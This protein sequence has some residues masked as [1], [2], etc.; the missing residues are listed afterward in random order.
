MKKYFVKSLFRGWCEVDK[1][2]FDSFVEF[3]R[4]ETL[5][6]PRDKKDEYIATRTKIVEE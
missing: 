4:K 1:E 3:L 5:N 6:I 2:M